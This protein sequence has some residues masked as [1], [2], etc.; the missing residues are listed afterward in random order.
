M[1]DFFQGGALPLSLW[2][3]GVVILGIALVYGV[4]RAGRLRT[5]DRQAV[6]DAT[7]MRQASEDPQKSVR[8]H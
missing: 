1:L 4:I 6:D 3:I 8:R 2:V 5:R 7:R